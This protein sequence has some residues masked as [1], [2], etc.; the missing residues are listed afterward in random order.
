MSTSDPEVITY[1]ADDDFDLPRWSNSAHSSHLAV[2]PTST[3]LNGGQ[4]SVYG[5]TAPP[6]QQPP[7]HHDHARLSSGQQQPSSSTRHPAH[8]PHLLEADP[9]SSGQDQGSQMMHMARST[10]M[11]TG[12]RGRRQ[13]DDLERAYSS[14]SQVVPPIPGGSVR[15]QINPFYPS[16]VAYQ[17]AASP[18]LGSHPSPSVDGY[19]YYG[20]SATPR[21]SQAH[22]RMAS[23]TNPAQSPQVLPQL[24]PY[25]QP[26]QQAAIFQSTNYPDYASSQQP[27]TNA[28]FSSQVKQEPPENDMRSSPYIPQHP[29]AP[30][31]STQPS[32]NL[33]YSTNSSYPS[34]DTQVTH[35]QLSVSSPSRPPSHSSPNTPF[36]HPHGQMQQQ[37]YSAPTSDHMNVESQP[38]RR[39]VGFKRVRDAKDLRPYLKPATSGRRLDHEGN[40]LS[41]RFLH[42][43]SSPVYHSPV[44]A[45][46]LRA[47]T[48]QIT[49]T[50]NLCNPQFRYESAHNPRRVLTKPSKPAHNDGY[51]NEDYDYIL[52]VNDWLGSEEGQK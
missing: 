31:M 27:S 3:Q 33:S 11:N 44:C 25:V 26:Q 42:H 15:Q 39:S 30:T 48:T 13:P 4:Y 49:A 35:P 2:Q 9:P 45:Q 34:M 5:Q 8:L 28:A 14:E 10:S 6:P 24:D 41:V 23:P 37:F 19:M 17:Q 36:S 40:Y 16:S 32:T 46:P 51:D 38:R 29:H 18:A 1:M 50:Y 20:S 47:L 21:R 52:Y 22:E 43:F 7:S 12:A